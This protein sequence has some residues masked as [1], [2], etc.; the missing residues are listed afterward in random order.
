MPET[1]VLVDVKKISMRYGATQALSGVSFQVHRGE[2]LGF[3]GPNGAGK[4][5]VMKTRWIT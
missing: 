3:L 1:D 2:I 5:T 4:S